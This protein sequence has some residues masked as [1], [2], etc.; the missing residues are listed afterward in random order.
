MENTDVKQR[1]RP[2][3]E[4]LPERRREEILEVATRIFAERG[5]PGTDVQVVADAA[6]I[7]KGTVYRYFPTKQD[8]FFAAVDRGL[9]VLKARIDEAQTAAG[10]DVFGQMKAV[11]VAYLAF[12][13]DNPAMVELLIQERAEFRD[14]AQ[15]AYFVRREEDLGRWHETL[16]QLIA[17]GRMRDVAPEQITQV[18]G[19]LLYGTMFANYVTGRHSDPQ[20]QAATILDIILHGLLTERGGA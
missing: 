13:E 7:G 16:R 8:L 1:G 17:A 2:R 5:Y 14:R 9:N 6:G 15:P 4:H 18:A 11:V 12:F 19:D 3:D 10:A 20:T